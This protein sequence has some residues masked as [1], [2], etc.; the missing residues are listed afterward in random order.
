MLKFYPLKNS[1]LKFLPKFAN[2]NINNYLLIIK[3]HV[4]VIDFQY[5]GNYCAKKFSQMNNINMHVKNTT[6]C[7]TTNIKSML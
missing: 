1:I 6:N 5:Q 2:M 3:V 7:L 4:H